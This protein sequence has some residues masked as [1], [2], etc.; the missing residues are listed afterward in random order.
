MYFFDRTILAARAARQYRSWQEG[1]FLVL[2]TLTALGGLYFFLGLLFDLRL[3][4]LNDFFNLPVSVITMIGIVAYSFG[5]AVF[6]LLFRSSPDQWLKELFGNLRA[7]PPSVLDKR[8]PP[9]K[10]LCL[11][12]RVLPSTPSDY[13]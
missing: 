10:P 6:L 4:T 2:L 8:F 3:K 1:L 9:A 12:Y 5:H 13:S 7:R 11:E